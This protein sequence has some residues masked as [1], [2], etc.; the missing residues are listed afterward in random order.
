MYLPYCTYHWVWCTYIRIQQNPRIVVVAEFKIWETVHASVLKISSQKR[1]LGALIQSS[2]AS[3]V[4]QVSGKASD[5]MNEH[6]TL[7]IINLS[8]LPWHIRGRSC[9][10]ESW[11]AC[12]SRSSILLIAVPPAHTVLDEVE[13]VSTLPGPISVLKSMGPPILPPECAQKVVFQFFPLLDM[14]NVHL[15]CSWRHA[16]YGSFIRGS[17]RWL[18]TVLHTGK[19]NKP[20]RWRE[21]KAFPLRFLARSTP[22]FLAISH[23]TVD[24]S[25]D[26]TV[27]SSWGPSAGKIQWGPLISSWLTPSS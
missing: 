26:V 21:R 4:S 3:K 5:I 23:R 10:W 14:S 20:Q 27:Q 1:H 15:Q 16:S 17:R 6:D 19:F 7:K 12:S 13:P 8:H 18:H 24:G 9:I 25:T 22:H 2:E 11:G